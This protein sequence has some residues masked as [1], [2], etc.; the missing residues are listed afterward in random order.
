MSLH[1]IL[2]ISREKHSVD[3][4]SLLPVDIPIKPDLVPLDENPTY[5]WKCKKHG[6]E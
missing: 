6:R 4:D 3:L 2:R 1:V 5:K